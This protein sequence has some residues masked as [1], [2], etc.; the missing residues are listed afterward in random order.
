MAVVTSIQLRRGTAA[1]WTSTNPTL[2]AGEMGVETDTSLS[3]IGDGTT[4][5]N[6]L[7]YG[8]SLAPLTINAQVGTTYTFA[9]TDSGDL[10]T[11]NNAASQTYTIPPLSSVAFATGTQITVL[12]KGAGAV[13]FAQGVGVTIRSSGGTPTAPTLRVQYS[14][15]TAI[16]EGSN[17]WYVVGDIA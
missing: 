7:T 14:S 3:K 17:I 9:L 11:A 5:W 15:A 12:R 4:A 1:Q 6:S 2:A 13:A 16:Y 10:I 8:S